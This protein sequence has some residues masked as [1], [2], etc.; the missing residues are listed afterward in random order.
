[1]EGSDGDW[2]GVQHVRAS[3]LWAGMREIDRI[4]FGNA[5]RPGVNIRACGQNCQVRK[6]RRA[7]RANVLL[8]EVDEF[9]LKGQRAN[10]ATLEGAEGFKPNK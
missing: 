7:W 8:T 10:P 2:A 1:M 5:R 9:G 3:T 6:V 4:A